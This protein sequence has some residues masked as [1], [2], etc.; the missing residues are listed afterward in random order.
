[1]NPTGQPLF[2]LVLLAS[3]RNEQEQTKKTPGRE[4]LPEKRFVLG[5]PTDVA[6]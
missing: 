3:R 6:Y 5:P 2:A 4:D 1:M